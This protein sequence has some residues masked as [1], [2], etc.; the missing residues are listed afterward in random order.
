MESQFRSALRAISPRYIARL[1]YK[2]AGI[3]CAW[4]LACEH[5]VH[6]E[7]SEGPSMYPT[8]NAR[9]DVLLVSR[10]HRNGKGIEVGDFVR[11]HHPSIL[12]VNAAKRVVGMPGDFVCRDEP[13]SAEVGAQDMIQVRYFLFNGFIL[14]HRVY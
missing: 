11:F 6:V 7:A 8:C 1:A 4:S 12:G 5:L 2:G 13:V 3:Y 10:L 9:G 14:L